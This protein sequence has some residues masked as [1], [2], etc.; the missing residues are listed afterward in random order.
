[1][2][3]VKE[4]ALQGVKVLAL[5]VLLMM[6]NGFASRFLPE[7][8]AADASA[9]ASGG[10]SVPS[11]SF[12]AIVFGVMLVQTHALA[13]PIV[14]A[15]WYG[16]K[17]TFTT[18]ILFFGTVT[19][20]G[21]LESLVYLGGKMPEGMLPGLFAMGFLTAAVFS[22]IAV[23][24]LKRWELHANDPPPPHDGAGISAGKIA[25]CGLVFVA[26]YYLFG[27]YVAWKNPA[28]REYY[29]GTDPGSFIAQMK[30]VVQ[31]SPWMLPFQY[32]RALLWV[33]LALLVIRMMKGP[34]WEAGIAT[35]VLFT[36]PSLY[37]LL[38]NP[39]MPEP[40]RMAHLVETVPY[41]F[42]YGWFAAW[43]FRSPGKSDLSAQHT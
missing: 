13:H 39:M 27:Y 42:L 15:K 29:N 8:P 1:M 43:L 33:G 20:M 17:L 7:M 37:L 34:W 35:A 21:Q 12:M 4:L 16:W 31:G 5:A 19:F 26:L 2:V 24:T 22:P 6:V 18:F 25:F 14:R 28:V 30:S 32:V 36:V 40:V 10:P 3:N 11:G 41:Q 23:V 9:E 38:P